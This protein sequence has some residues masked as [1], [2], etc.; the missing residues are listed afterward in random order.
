[1]CKDCRWECCLALF[2]FQCWTHSHSAVDEVVVYKDEKQKHL[3]EIRCPWN[4]LSMR[5]KKYLCNHTL[6]E[7]RHRPIHKC[8]FPHTE[9]EQDIWNV[10]NGAASANA[11]SRTAVSREK[12]PPTAGYI[13]TSELYD[14][15]ICSHSLCRDDSLLKL[16]V[17][18]G[19]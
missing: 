10:W 6:D 4:Y 15:C 8:G 9:V 13:Y 17:L 18:T 19:M 5:N 11:S 2:Q 1:M 7:C 3:V 14:H 12:Q 16:K